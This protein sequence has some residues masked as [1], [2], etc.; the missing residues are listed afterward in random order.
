MLLAGILSAALHPL[1]DFATV[2][3]AIETY[4]TPLPLLERAVST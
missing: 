2:V 3:M 4:L 1:L